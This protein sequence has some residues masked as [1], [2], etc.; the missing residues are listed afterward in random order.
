MVNGFVLQYTRDI[1]YHV[2]HA[3]MGN[4]KEGA[5]EA[6]TKDRDR[7]VHDKERALGSESEGRD[8]SVAG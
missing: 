4:W 3:S 5:V 1:R 7:S 6:G 8:R 2:C